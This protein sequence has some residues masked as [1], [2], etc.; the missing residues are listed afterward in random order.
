MKRRLF[1]YYAETVRPKL[2][3]KDPCSPTRNCTYSAGGFR[4]KM[5][6][7]FRHVWPEHS[8]VR[9]RVAPISGRRSR[10]DTRSAIARDQVSQRKSERATRSRRLMVGRCAKTAVFLLSALCIGT[11]VIGVASR[12]SIIRDTLETPAR[13][14]I[15]PPSR[16]WVEVA[17]CVVS[18]RPGF[19]S[20]LS[21]WGNPTIFC[22]G[23]NYA[24]RIGPFPTTNSALMEEYERIKMENPVSCFEYTEP[25]GDYK[26][27][28][29]NSTTP[30][31]T[32]RCG[33]VDVEDL[34]RACAGRGL[35]GPGCQEDWSRA[36]EYGDY[37]HRG[38]DFFHLTFD[39]ND[40]GKHNHV[41]HWNTD[42]MK[43]FSGIRYDVVHD[44]L[45]GSNNYN[46]GS[47]WNRP[48]FC[49]SRSNFYNT[50]VQV[51]I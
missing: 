28:D 27:C 49:G 30:M 26:W 47:V 10:T 46:C 2:S 3:H 41:H 44:R 42:S 35:N 22:D 20:A 4:G 23:N 13:R 40:D 34:E 45:A 32:W 14:N 19:R 29:A 33:Q 9:T 8:F 25:Y 16:L 24:H 18:S 21:E 5:A 50:Y 1:Q 38:Y 43:Y 36:E 7:S 31:S 11:H 39:V 15:R 37:N 51:V 6:T 12:L 48:G 17:R